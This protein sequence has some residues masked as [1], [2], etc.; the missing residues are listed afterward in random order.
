MIHIFI[1]IKDKSVRCPGKNEKLVSYTLNY[2]REFIN[3]NN[4]S[5]EL[6]VIIL[7]NSHYFDSLK[8]QYSFISE[9][10][11]EDDFN[12]EANNELIS[13]YKYIKYKEIYKFI[14]LPV[15]QPCRSKELL[16]NVIELMNNGVF[17]N[18]NLVTSYIERPNRMIF[19]LENHNN[20]FDFKI[21][22]INRKGS[23]CYTTYICDGAIYASTEKFLSQCI[24]SNDIYKT[25]WNTQ[26]KFIKNN[27]PLV[28]ID[29]I[30]ELQKFITFFK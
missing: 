22:N 23:L 14:L 20:V 21:K 9:I 1:P 10:W 6:N 28:D 30:D 16:K 8:D 2:I 19:E 15:T 11:I 18:Y 7:T 17:Y 12:I 24:N 27:A 5:E 26:T 13:I 29:T 3:D 25:F 4:T